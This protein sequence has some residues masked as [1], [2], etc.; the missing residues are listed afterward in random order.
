MINLVLTTG[1]T[2]FSSRDM[3]PEATLAVVERETRG[4]P[5]AMRAES[6]KITPRGCLSRS[7][8]GIRGKT[9]IVNLPGSEKAAGE[10][11]MAMID[12]VRH[13]VEMLLSGCS[14]DCAQESIPSS[15][16][17]PSMDIWLREAKADPGANQIGM[18]LIYN[19]VVRK[20]AR[21]AV[22][23]AV[24]TTVI[25]CGMMVSYD[26]EKVSSTIEDPYKMEGIS[27]IKVCL[28]ERTLQVGED[29]MY[30]LIGGDIRPHVAQ[31]LSYLVSRLKHECITEAELF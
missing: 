29:I 23:H 1:D 14:A 4:I 9:L 25:V 12:S 6:M 16:E 21:E 13:G 19:G 7:A 2:G 28:N 30:V 8:A 15:K 26:R 17:V 10:N 3:T 24:K 5:E 22:L 20:T 11:L 27:Y 31:A 18:Y